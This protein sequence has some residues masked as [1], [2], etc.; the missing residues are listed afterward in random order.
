MYTGSTRLIDLT[1]DDF[2]Q[3]IKETTTTAENTKADSGKVVRGLKAIAAV[4]GI[5]ESTLKEWRKDGT[6]KEPVISQKRRII[7]A[8]ESD[9]IAF[10]PKTKKTWTR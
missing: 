6:I 5:S 10:K 9:L 1:V 3:L 2:R 7:T 8:N 4:L